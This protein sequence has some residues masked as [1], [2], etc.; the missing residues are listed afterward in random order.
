MMGQQRRSNSRTAAHKALLVDVVC[1]YC[2]SAHVTEIDH[3]IPWSRGGSDGV[4]SGNLV[5]TCQ[6]CNREKFNRTLDEWR[7]WRAKRGGSW[8]PPNPLPMIAK[9]LRDSGFPNPTDEQL[10]YTLD[11]YYN[12]SGPTNQ[13]NAYDRVNRVFSKRWFDPIIFDMVLADLPAPA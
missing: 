11:C 2:G 3:V 10:F 12:L 6:W 7:E 1:A 5:P 4:D 9:V 8:P 13:F